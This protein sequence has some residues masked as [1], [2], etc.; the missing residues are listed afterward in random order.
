MLE[1]L[2]TE[3]PVGEIVLERIRELNGTLKTLK[4]HQLVSEELT[5]ADKSFV[6]AGPGL[7]TMLNGNR[8]PVD[9]VRHN[10]DQLKDAMSILIRGAEIGN[11]ELDL[12]TVSLRGI[13]PK[14][15]IIDDS[16]IDHLKVTHSNNPHT[17][18]IANNSRIKLL[19]SSVEN[20]NFTNIIKVHKGFSM[21]ALVHRHGDRPL[22]DGD[23][24]QFAISNVEVQGI[25]TDASHVSLN[26]LRN[27][28]AIIHPQPSE[29]SFFLKSVGFSFDLGRLQS[30]LMWKSKAKPSRS[31]W[32]RYFANPAKTTDDRWS[33]VD[34]SLA[35]NAALA[36]STIKALYERSSL[37]VSNE[38]YSRYLYFLNSRTSKLRRFLYWFNGAYYNVQIPL[39][40]TSLF[41]GG[42]ILSLLHGKK[43]IS[44]LFMI[45]DPKHLISNYLFS[46]LS[47]TNAIDFSKYGFALCLLP[48][49]YSLFCLGLAL[50][51][52]FGFP[53]EL[54]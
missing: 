8:F 38:E 47:I 18:I 15:L 11:W 12:D 53:N 6:K 48:F 54:K 30:G 13:R 17:V 2:T 42:M 4:V 16:S 49:Y 34:L 28:N 45:I 43:A 7:L 40:A 35:D 51:R 32:K 10:A 41:L 31:L 22:I 46:D 1:I 33:R 25:Y 9:A 39:L 36:E 44:E 37:M 50:K 19:Q 52:K 29:A 14:F 21:V 5:W 27:V 20:F 26:D 23:Q 24:R 3:L